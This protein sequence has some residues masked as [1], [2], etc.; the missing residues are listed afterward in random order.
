MMNNVIKVRAKVLQFV[1]NA[2]VDEFDSGVFAQF[3]GTELEL[4]SSAHMQLQRVWIYH[5]DEVPF[6]SLWRK[7]NETICFSIQKQD[8]EVA[9]DLF[10]SAVWDV[11]SATEP[12]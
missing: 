4:T 5:V 10:D 12:Q 11:H 2:M 8:L 6:D 3:D 7:V 9:K 1:P